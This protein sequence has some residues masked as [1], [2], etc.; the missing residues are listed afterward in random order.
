MVLALACP[1]TLPLGRSPPLSP[2]QESDTTSHSSVESVLEQ[3]VRQ[4]GRG[5]CHT[6]GRS[7]IPL[8]NLEISSVFTFSLQFSNLI[9]SV[10]TFLRALHSWYSNL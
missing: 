3:E 7:Q 6:N 5:S 2:S 8:T 10:V 9:L 1:V 4:R